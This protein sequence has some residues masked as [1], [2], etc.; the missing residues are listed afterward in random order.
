MTFFLSYHPIFTLPLEV[1]M[2]A[3][4]PQLLLAGVV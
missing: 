3:L 2:N 1:K 4:V